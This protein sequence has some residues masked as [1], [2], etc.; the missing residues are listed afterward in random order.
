MGSSE[1]RTGE[2]SMSI[3]QRRS[4]DGESFNGRVDAV[5]SCA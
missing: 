4:S 5:D 3:K 1:L 2:A